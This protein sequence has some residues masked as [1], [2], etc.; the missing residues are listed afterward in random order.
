MEIQ[1]DTRNLRVQFRFGV[2]EKPVSHFFFNT[3]LCCKTYSVINGILSFILFIY[4]VEKLSMASLLR[5]FCPY[6]VYKC[7]VALNH[8]P[9]LF[10]NRIFL[11]IFLLYLCMQFINCNDLQKPGP[12]NQ[13][14]TN[15]TL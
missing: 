9:F 1:Y 10:F 6:L 8:L 5:T 2:L 11:A 15:V 14:A 12:S 13:C 7:Q 3:Y 4:Y